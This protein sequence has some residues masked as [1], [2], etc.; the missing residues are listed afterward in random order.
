[1]LLVPKPT[2]AANP[3]TVNFQG[4]VTNPNGTNVTDGSYSFVFRLYQNVNINTYNP[5]SLTCSADTNCWWEE[6]DTLTVTNGVFQVELGGVCAFSSAC[7]SGHSGINFNAQNA[8]SLTMKFNSDAAGY[9][10]PLLHLQSVPYAY[11]SDSL[12]GIAA[13]NYVQL[14]N[15]LQTDTSSTNASI[16][17]NKTGGTANILTLQQAGVDT[18]TINNSGSVLSR[19]NVNSSTAFQVQNSAS[20]N[21]L[22][23]DT[24]NMRLGV[25]VT[26]SAMSAPASPAATNPVQTVITSV[27]PTGGTA[28]SYTYEVVAATT[29]QDGNQAASTPVTNATGPA[30]LSATAYE[31]INITP[32]C[33]YTCYVYRTS[34]GGSPSST[35]LIGTTTFSSFVDDGR[36][37]SGG[38]APTPAGSL[39][40]ATQYFYKITAIDSAGGETLPSTE[41]SATT[42]AGRLTNDVSWTMVDGATSYKVYRSTTSNAEVY[43]TTVVGNTTYNNT[44][45]Y[46]T[47]DGSITIGS[48]TVPTTATAKVSTNN[49]ASTVQLTIGGLGTATGQVY[50]SGMAPVDITSGGVASLNT[51][52]AVGARPLYVVGDYAYVLNNGVNKL[53]VFDVSNPTSP[54]NLTG[55]GVS[56]GTLPQAV[57]V[58]GHYA[59]VISRTSAKLQVFDISNPAIPLDISNGGVST[60]SSPQDLYVRGS[61]VYIV[62]DT[63]LQ[64]F[65]VSMPS[66]PFDVSS[67]GVACGITC[68][69][70]YLQGN[71]AYLAGDGL[72]AFDVSNPSSPTNVSG[73]GIAVS[74]S[75]VYGLFIQGKYL[76]AG[77]AGTAWSI[78]DI[79]NP[80]TIIHTGDAY[81]MS[82]SVAMFVQGRYA[83]SIDSSQYKLNVVDVSNPVKP[84]KIAS[85]AT[86]GASTDGYGLFV[87]GH[88]AYV[89]SGNKIQI[90]ELGGTYTQQLEAGGAKV[91]SLT[92]NGNSQ[93]T[94][95]LSLQGGLQLGQSIQVSGNLGLAGGANLLGGVKLTGGKNLLGAPTNLSAG[96]ATSG[97]SLSGVYKYY[98]TAYDA[99]GGETTLSNEVTTASLGSPNQT[100][101]L[102]WTAVSGASGYKV[103]RTASAGSSNSEKALISVTTNS[104]TDNNAVTLSAAAL[105][106]GPD[107]TGQLTVQGSA[108][109]RNSA[110][111][112]TAFQVQNS[113]GASIL[114]ID[115]VNLSL[116]VG[117]ATD[118]LTFTAGTYEPVLNGSARHTRMMT[119]VPEYP[120]AVLT[121]D[122]ANNTGTMTS[123]FCSGSSLRNIPSASNPCAASVEHNYYTW[124]TTSQNDYDIWLRWQIPSDFSD[125]AASSPITMYGW[126]TDSTATTTVDLSLYNASGTLCGTTTNVA[127]GTAAWT[128]TALGGTITSAGCSISAGN[129]VSFRMQMNANNKTVRAGELTV[130]YLSKW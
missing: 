108:L 63:K 57:N 4:K 16:A 104:Y 22:T 11:N 95:D 10:T 128:S 46:F 105:P 92:V 36:P 96:A 75:Y 106:S 69:R 87:Q 45:V 14:A 88:Y 74:A 83:Y 85:V 129:V 118:N 2:L 127:T 24:T 82:G 73:K 101:P 5:N 81:T 113:S 3:A 71:Y 20:T 61:N 40:T 107:S 19:T 31:T 64:I 47:D 55:S 86:A 90:F 121:G 35:G 110:D 28:T 79:S 25:D 39:T 44:T 52:A 53:Q 68:R 126:R 8:L 62:N 114:N 33:T 6:S 109:F 51:G 54:V 112:S 76:Y 125:F 17:I 103:Y 34:S 78:F 84:I 91:G 29:T 98:V 72:V 117:N 48:A 18:F 27:V 49:S 23:A 67:G 60:V 13:A 115:S 7:N 93:L 100:E 111:S 50:V 56:T 122:G 120:G 94:G 66:S 30:V 99:F 58:Q 37:A 130:N 26:Y 70:I 42:A 43:L 59:Y 38:S 123:D 12:G 41:V 102:T 116:R 21:L 89:Y 65:D 1:M 15:G 97:G 124:V 80:A 9:M 77:T 32:S 119:F